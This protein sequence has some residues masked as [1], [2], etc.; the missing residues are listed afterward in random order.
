M[1][2]AIEVHPLEQFF[3][4]PPSAG[5]S[6]L[7]IIFGASGDLTRRKLVPG[8]YNL[9]CVGCMNPQFEVLGVGR[10]QMRTE[11][12]RASMREALMSS[13]DARDFTETGWR[14]FE[15]HLNYYVGDINDDKF[16]SQLRDHL[17][18]TQRTGSSRN[19]LF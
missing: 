6:C 19:R 4:E 5:D 3:L 16:Y 1:P 17:D 13:N 12:F 2:A 15:N 9:S 18:Q 14:E 11:D 10:T 7:L 8:L